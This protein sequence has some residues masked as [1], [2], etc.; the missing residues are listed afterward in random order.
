MD[1]LLHL[2]CSNQ[3]LY[4]TPGGK[5]GFFFLS[6]SRFLSVEV[7]K[8]NICGMQG[9][10]EEPAKGAELT[11][12]LTNT[13]SQKRSVSLLVCTVYSKARTS[14]HHCDGCLAGDPAPFLITVSKWKNL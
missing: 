14:I 13:I 10:L 1:L 7:T 5:Q 12:G 6:A 8:K 2:L 4:T 9:G 3:A 11:K